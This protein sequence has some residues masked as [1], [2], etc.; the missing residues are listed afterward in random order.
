VPL[1][2]EGPTWTMRG[3]PSPVAV[4]FRTAIGALGPACGRCLRRAD[5]GYTVD[6]GDDRTFAEGAGL[7]AQGTGTS[8]APYRRG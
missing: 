7:N 2:L 3:V 6:A 1:T 4:T 8:R 5:T